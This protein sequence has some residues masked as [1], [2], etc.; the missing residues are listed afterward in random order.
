MEFIFRLGSSGTAGITMHAL[1]A[2]D[3]LVKNPTF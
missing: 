1:A 3:S 2:A